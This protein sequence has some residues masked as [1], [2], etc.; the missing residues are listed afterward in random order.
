MIESMGMHDGKSYHTMYVWDDDGQSLYG[1]IKHFSNA[2]MAPK[3]PVGDYHISRAEAVALVLRKA[4][5]HAVAVE[6]TQTV[7]MK[8]RWYRTPEAIEVGKIKSLSI[9]ELSKRL[10]PT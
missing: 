2:K 5:Y 4:G 9:K 1:S 3:V 7:Y 8:E 6:S 10:S